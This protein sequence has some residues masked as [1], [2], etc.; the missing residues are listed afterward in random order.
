MTVTTT[1]NKVLPETSKERIARL[2]LQKKNSS[3]GTHAKVL[4]AQIANEPKTPRRKS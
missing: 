4:A 3:A 1:P 2:A